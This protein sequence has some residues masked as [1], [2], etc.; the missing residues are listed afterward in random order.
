M[1]SSVPTPASSDLVGQT[2]TWPVLAEAE[3]HGVAV[4]ADWSCDAVAGL[5]A[6]P[7]TQLAPLDGWPPHRRPVV[8]VFGVHLSGATWLGGVRIPLGRPYH[9]LGILV[10][11][12][13]EPGAPAGIATAVV[14]MYADYFPAVWNGRSR[15]G[16][17][18]Q[19]AVLRWCDVSYVAVDRAG[20]LL[21]A[22]RTEPCGPWGRGSVPSGLRAIA[23]VFGVPL[24]GWSPAGRR[25]S[26]PSRWDLVGAAVRPV[27]TSL[28]WRGAVA[29]GMASTELVRRQ[30]AAFEVRGVRW[31]L[32]WPAPVANRT[33][34]S[35]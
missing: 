5:L 14:A 10:P 13:A 28:M 7:S 23:E 34:G 1:L 6:R 8:V 11:G 20:G 21:G 22:A 29:A 19:E 9:E 3:L 17:A 26:T 30:V 18:K 15:Y 24:L 4:M 32:G 33:S 16:F 12:V 27:R 2:P 35:T 31:Q 25:I